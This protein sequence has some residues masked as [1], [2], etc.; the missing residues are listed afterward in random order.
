MSATPKPLTQSHASIIGENGAVVKQAS[1]FWANKDSKTFIHW[2]L[3]VMCSICK[4]DGR[5]LEPGRTLHT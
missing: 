1:N 5:R 3:A 2:S 4:A